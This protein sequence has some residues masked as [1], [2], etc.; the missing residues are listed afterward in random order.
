MPLNKINPVS[1]S[2]ICYAQSVESPVSLEQSYR[3]SRRITRLYAKTFYFASHLLPP[4]RRRAA[5]ALYAFCRTADSITDEG[6]SDPVAAL[7]ELRHLINEP[8]YHLHLY[9]WAPAWHHTIRHYR[10][11]PGLFLELVAGVEM[12]LYKARYETFDE[13]YQYCYRVASVVGLMMVPVLGYTSD[14]AFYHA[15]KLG[16]AMQLT[17][18]LR[19]VGEDLERGRIYLPLAELRSVGY[20]E[21]ALLAREENTAF[22][23]VMRMQVERAR[24]Y[25]CEGRAGIALLADPAGRLTVRLMANLYEAILDE[26]EKRQYPSLRQRVHVSLPRKVQRSIPEVFAG[27]SDL[28]T[29]GLP[30]GYV[31]LLLLLIGISLPAFVVVPLGAFNSWVWMDSLYLT[32]WGSAA[33]LLNLQNR[34]MLLAAFL[35]AIAGL[36]AEIVGVH[37]GML[38][39]RYTYTETLQ[40]Q[41]MEVPIPIALA[42]GALVS[43]SVHLAAPMP[44]L[45]RALFV[46]LLTVGMDVLLE[47]FATQVKSYW[48]WAGGRVPFSNYLTWGILAGLLSMM[49]P[50]AP[51]G[52]ALRYSAVIL[53]GVLIVLLLLSILSHGMWMAGF[54]GSLLIGGAFLLRKAYSFWKIRRS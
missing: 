15:E 17:N 23:A 54:A 46:A 12:D 31:Y 49:F 47:P 34:R 21:Q 11:E 28:L 45:W 52:A 5:Y 4:A 10:I 51:G 40:P 9:P 20:S 30:R 8:E 43:L 50:Q 35:A 38:F 25:Y 36:F 19:D 42:W 26:L 39:G 44:L 2:E 22:H 7:T 16:I 53:S 27:M 1:C 6:H 3:E 32:L 33:I 18:I 14:R 29:H 24:A 48:T 41:L 13:L 37:T